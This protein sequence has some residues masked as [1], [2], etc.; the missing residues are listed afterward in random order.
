MSAIQSSQAVEA[1]S[2]PDSK[3]TPSSRDSAGWSSPAVLGIAA[4]IGAVTAVTWMPYYP[5]W[6]VSYIALAVVVACALV[7]HGGREPL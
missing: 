6:S 3:W 7:S 2:A 5:V 4:A 1:T